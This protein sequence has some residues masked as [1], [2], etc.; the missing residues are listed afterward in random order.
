MART[1]GGKEHLEAAKKLLVKAKTADELRTAQA[2]AFPHMFGFSIDRTATAIG[3]TVGITCK[4]RKNIALLEK[5]KK[6]KPRSKQ[7]LRNRAIATPEQEAQILNEVFSQ[8]AKDS[9]ASKLKPLI[10]A[11]L[12]KTIVLGTVYNM[13]KRHKQRKLVPVKKSPKTQLVTEENWEE[14]ESETEQSP[15]DDHDD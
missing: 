7:E 11:K 13:L 12:G 14:P 5:V 9:S 10:E 6:A 1:P 3:R 4:M 8:V 15:W 2:I